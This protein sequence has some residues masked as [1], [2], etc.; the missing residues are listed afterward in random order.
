MKILIIEDNPADAHMLARLLGKLSLW[1]IET[2]I[3]L[4]EDHLE[5]CSCLASYQPS[6]VFVDYL[7]GATTGM[8]IIQK[9]VRQYPETAFIVLTGQGDEGIASQAMRA[10]ALDYL[11]KDELSLSVLE[12]T[13]RYVTERKKQAH[14]LR[15][16]RENLERLVEE[17]TKELS[18]AK[19]LAERA[20]QTKSEFLAN[21]SHELRTPMHAI[22]SFSNMGM[23]KNTGD[24]RLDHYF[25]R[26]AANGERLMKLLDNLLDLSRLEAGQMAFQLKETQMESILIASVMTLRSPLQKKKIRLETMVTPDMPPMMVDR[27]CLRQLVTHLLG[28]AIRFSPEGGLINVELTMA[29]A[30]TVARFT[31]RDQGLGIPENELNQVFDRFT[32]SSRTRSSAGGTGLGLAICRKIVTAHDGRITAANHA[33]GGAIFTVD[34]PIQK[35]T[36]HSP[37]EGRRKKTHKNKGRI[38]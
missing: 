9:N 24:A 12:R 11:V 28:N 31:V 22:L 33:E 29:M 23:K 21:I 15:L 5:Q 27:V 8:D 37:P 2:H 26:I 32:Q 10:G 36:V 4:E 30:N 20:N 6:L 18:A 3:C 14:E 35:V 7:L 19:E 25:A 17:R 16:Y 34:L 1:I 38:F 13:L